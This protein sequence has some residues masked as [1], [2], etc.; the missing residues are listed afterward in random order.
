MGTGDAAVACPNLYGN[1]SN[2]VPFETPIGWVIGYNYIGDHRMLEQQNHWAVASPVRLTD[3]GS[4]PLFADLND[5]SPQDRWTIVPHQ[6]RGGGGFFYGAQGG[7]EPSV[8]GSA[9][10]NVAFLDGS[11]RWKVGGPLTRDP[12]N[13]YIDRAGEL[14][15]YYTAGSP[16]T[17][18]V[19]A[20]RGLW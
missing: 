7:G 8:Y 14:L 19:E 3:R 2:P 4:L 13:K 18:D 12:V 11:V 9:G 20:Y 15:E 17:T 5:W 1:D 10:G 6:A 16:G